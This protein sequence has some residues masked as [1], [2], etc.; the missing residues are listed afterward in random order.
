MKFFFAAYLLLGALIA[1]HYGLAWDETESRHLGQLN[2]DYLAG[3]P[4][5]LS[6]PD[7]L[8][9]P[10][11]EIALAAVER[12]LGVTD[13]RYA[14]LLRHFLTFLVFFAA[15]VV[16]YR[17]C[18]KRF[19]P[20]L[21]AA[22]AVFFIAHPRIF[23]HSFFNSRDIGFLAAVVFAVASLEAF[24]EKPG[25]RTALA[26][27]AFTGFAIATRIM[28]VWIPLATLIVARRNV[29]RRELAVYGIAA[30]FFTVL[31]WPYLWA[32][33]AGRFLEALRHSSRVPWPWTV[34]YGS[35]FHQAD[36]LPWHY[37]P[38]WIAITTPP[39]ILALFLGGVGRLALRK[40]RPP[41]DLLCAAWFFIPVAAVIALRPTLLDEWRYLFFVYPALVWL[42]L[43]A[44]EGLRRTWPRWLALAA[45][46]PSLAFMARAHPFENVY[47]NR[48]AGKDLAEIRMR[49]EMDYWGLSY[50]RILERIAAR[51]ARPLIRV[52]AETE[53][54]VFN[55]ALLP[56]SD[57]GRFEFVEDTTNADY[58]ITNYRWHPGDHP[59]PVF[60]AVVVDGA[61]IAAAYKLR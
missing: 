45:L 41:A 14:F 23:A 59:L 31:F 19:G 24:L 22:G 7:R 20:G 21:A 56:R 49:Y 8:I 55:A 28:G 43:V 61:R 48:L 1:G 17:L 37:M 47:F 27:A 54:G 52:C 10:A 26:H 5:L 42:A 12:A 46:A 34:L 33:P 13:P 50:R 4:A 60:E 9:G 30:A 44:L 38:V 51:D 15:A 57:R 53:P 29:R 58:F 6:E 25:P 18:R 39:V 35:A 3:D 16:F 40:K 32:D 2:L 11:L 36:G